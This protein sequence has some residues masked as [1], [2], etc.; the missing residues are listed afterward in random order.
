MEP[1]L[2]AALVRV[3]MFLLPYDV[4][5]GSTDKYGDF[6]AHRVWQVTTTSQPLAA[7]YTHELL[8]WG[9]DYPPLFAYFS[10]CLGSVASVLCPELL[11]GGRGYCSRLDT[12]PGCAPTWLFMRASVALLDGLTLFPAAYLLTRQLGAPPRATALALLLLLLHP[13]QLLIDHGHFQ[14]NGGAIGLALLAASQMQ[15]RPLL[16][17]ALFTLALNLKHTA[18]YYAPVFLALLLAQAVLGFGAWWPARTPC[19]SLARV[20]ALAASVLATMAALWLPFCLQQPQGQC[21]AGL[22][23]VATRLAPLDRGLYEDT[24]ANLWYATESLT[25]LQR[26]HFPP[27]HDGANASSP[28]L[29]PAYRAM[30]L[31]CTA[32][33]VLLAAPSLLLLWRAAMLTAGGTTTAA[34][35]S[36]RNSSSSSSLTPHLLLTLHSSALA[37]FLASFHVHEKAVLFS[38]LPLALLAPRLPS[39]MAQEFMLLS[40]ASM[41]TLLARDGLLPLAAMLCS[42]H[43]LLGELA[44]AAEGQRGV[45]AAAAQAASSPATPA[46]PLASRLA[47]LLHSYMRPAWAAAL[48]LVAGGALVVAPPPGLP[49]LFSK[50]NATLCAAGLL[51]HLLWALWVQLQWVQ[52]LPEAQQEAQPVARAAARRGRRGSSSHAHA[53]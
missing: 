48:A 3:S 15:Q 11:T 36:S 41:G 35:R 4:G 44:V 19:H 6:E 33:S 39:G 49:H 18:I 40:V 51:G 21:L 47:L 28:H 34:T 37:F 7:W 14:Y 5:L 52:A 16:S 17:A 9:L 30:A 22:A 38:A 20:A 29:S 1:F 46:W 26:D 23:A 27:T 25:H 10:Y 45:G 53:Q 32:A 43:V 24:V 8:Y 31:A 2:V 50:L 42:A 12:L 13:A